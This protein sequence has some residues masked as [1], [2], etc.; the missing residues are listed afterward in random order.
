MNRDTKRDGVRFGRRTL[1][2]GLLGAATAVYV[3]PITPP[4]PTERVANPHRVDDADFAVLESVIEAVVS[5]DPAF[6]PAR[7]LD[8]RPYF[9]NLLGQM[10]PFDRDQFLRLLSLLQYSTA[11]THRSRFT[12]LSV[13]ARAEALS[14]WAHSS[15]TLRRQA[16]TALKMTAC[17]VYFAA[18][19]A[20]VAVGY[21]GPW[22]DQT[23]I[24]VLDPPPLSYYVEASGEKSR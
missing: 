20:W 10:A 15:L 9:E 6:P 24:V 14:S 12:N 8:L 23:E 19:R 2:E 22:V 4:A 17:M 16:F 5:G 18:D 1:L 21:D 3:G 7:E 11:L 13:E